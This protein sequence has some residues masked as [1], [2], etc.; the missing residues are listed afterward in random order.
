MY[1]H[2]HHRR[3]YYSSPLVANTEP[4]SFKVERESE[5]ARPLPRPLQDQLFC[6]HVNKTRAPDHLPSDG[7]CICMT[8]SLSLLYLFVRVYTYTESTLSLMS[9]VCYLRWTIDS[10][11]SSL[12]AFL[13]LCVW[14]W[15]VCIQRAHCDEVKS[16]VCAARVLQLVIFWRTDYRAQMKNALLIW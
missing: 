11:A 5:I 13:F 3:A 14:C 7:R 4:E 15:C 8:P 10:S 2:A 16:F 1:I 12:S 9:L 6:M